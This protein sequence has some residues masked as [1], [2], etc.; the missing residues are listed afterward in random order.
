MT[1]SDGH[2]AKR[3]QVKHRAKSVLFFLAGTFFILIGGMSAVSFAAEKG[4]I[5]IGFLSPQTGN[6][7]QMGIDMAEGFKM[8]LD[9]A[10]Y[11]VAGRKVELV[12]EDEGADAATGVTKVRKVINHDKANL[13]AGIFFTA[14]AYAVAPICEEANVPLVIAVSAGDDLTQR[15][16]SKWV[17]RVAFTGCELG[18]VAGDYAYH[19]LGWRKAVILGFDYAWGYENGGGF[20]RT[21][22]ENGGKIIQKTWAPLNTMDFGPYISRLNREADGIFDV[23]TGAAS[24]RFIRSL[25]E[26]GLMDKWKVLVPGT[27]ADE[28]ILP[29]MGDSGLGVLSVLPYS[30]ALKTPENDQFNEKLRN[31]KKE[32]S[33]GIAFS[34]TAG[35]WI[36]RAIKAVNG[37]VENKDK[38]LQALRAVEIPNSLR[39]PLK[40]DKYGHVI[41]NMYI[42]RIDKVGNRYQN[43]V[44]ET[45]PMVSQFFRFDPETYLKS[46]VYSRDFPPCRFCE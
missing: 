5:R 10:N 7:A 18:H 30:A 22:E 3:I 32:A 37:D 25:R 39:G 26:S 4:P 19:K 24:L 42:R 43:T 31:L 23:I 44:I 46:P 33:L 11:T 29:A 20:Q 9:E 16:R 38:F 41:Q 40:M 35:D 12:L 1:L 17:T 13:I 15:K 45:Y 27:G 8:F 6:F 21:F 36:F 2:F 28:T 14:A 34:Y